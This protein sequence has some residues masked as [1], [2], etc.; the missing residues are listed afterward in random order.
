MRVIGT[1]DAAP[2][3][4]TGATGG[5]GGGGGGGFKKGGFKSSFASI[6]G[7][8]APVKKNVLGDEED[9]EMSGNTESVDARATVKPATETETQTG[10]A[11]SDTDEEYADSPGGYY[12][13]RYP[14]GCF[15]GCPGA[16]SV[17]A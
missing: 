10:G 4:G 11:E 9:E 1:G 16:R 15:A 2:P 13:P 6:K 5:G 3:T 14:T 7:P 12:N 17:V 8:T